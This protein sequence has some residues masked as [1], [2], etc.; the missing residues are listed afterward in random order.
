MQI[1]QSLVETCARS[2]SMK[3]SAQGEHA[4]VSVAP[5]TSSVEFSRHSEM[6]TNQVLCLA[7]LNKLEKAWIEMQGEGAPRAKGVF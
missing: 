5:T 3:G 7:A 6:A 4:R 2:F 1:S